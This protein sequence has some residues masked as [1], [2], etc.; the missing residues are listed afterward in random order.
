MQHPNHQIILGKLLA[1]MA[2][3]SATSTLEHTTSHSAR[4]P[5]YTTVGSIYNPNAEK[6]LQPP[7]R[8]GRTIRLSHMNFADP[9]FLPQPSGFSDL[10]YSM[11]DCSP[12]TAPSFHQ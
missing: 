11:K 3:L 9:A 2:S 10:T 4:Q 8:R 12:P 6:P 7:T 5:T 1:D